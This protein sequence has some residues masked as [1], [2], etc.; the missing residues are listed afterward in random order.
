MTVELSA[1]EKHFASPNK[2]V[3]LRALKLLL[4]H[5]GAT[6]LQLAR[7]L[8]SPDNRNGEFRK[9]FELHSAMRAAWRRLSGVTDRGVYQY[10]SDLY[11]ADPASNVDSVLGVLM[12]LGTPDALALAK[13]IEPTLPARAQ[14]SFAM[15]LNTIAVRAEAK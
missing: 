12:H 4:R 6:P 1:I 11:L 9:V 7:A 8:C 15:V 14:R 5:P 3:R 13:Q 2:Q 10:L